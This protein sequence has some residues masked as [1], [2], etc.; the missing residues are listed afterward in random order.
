MGMSFNLHHNKQAQEVI[1]SR[2][3]NT[4]TKRSLYFN[5]TAVEQIPV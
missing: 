1:F 4:R 2:K 3:T 5:N